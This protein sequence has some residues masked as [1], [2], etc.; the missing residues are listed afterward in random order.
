MISDDNVVLGDLF[1]I[2]TMDDL[3]YR[4]WIIELITAK[5]LDA[6]KISTWIVSV[7]SGGAVGCTQH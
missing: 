3:V 1:R 6:K 5:L 4:F 2:G 7:P